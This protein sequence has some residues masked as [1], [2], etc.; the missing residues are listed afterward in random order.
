MEA[1]NTKS[2]SVSFS[3]K[4]LTCEILASKVRFNVSMPARYGTSYS[5]LTS[6]GRIGKKSNT[7]TTPA[8]KRIVI[9]ISA[10]KERSRLCLLS[11]G[12]G[13]EEEAPASALGNLG[14]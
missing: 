5:L 4:K 2:L 3:D 7:K 14:Q 11:S 1:F 13:L 9:S 10:E 12:L 8:T 6:T